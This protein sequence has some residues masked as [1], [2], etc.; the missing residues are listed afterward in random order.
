MNGPSE[1]PITMHSAVV[2]PRVT[3]EIILSY[4]F[5]VLPVQNKP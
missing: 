5:V 3:Y 4:V 2:S 1:T